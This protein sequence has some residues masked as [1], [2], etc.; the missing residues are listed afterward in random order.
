M[1]Q[2]DEKTWEERY[3]NYAGSIMSVGPSTVLRK[4]I[5]QAL[6]DLGLPKDTKVLLPGCGQNQHVPNS[7]MSVKNIA[8]VT[9]V[10]FPPVIA[11]IGPEERDQFKDGISLVPGDMLEVAENPEFKEA[12]KV[13]VAVNFPVAETPEKNTALLKAC[14]DCL[15]PG[16]YLIIM[17]PDIAFSQSLVDFKAT[18]PKSPKN[19]IGMKIAQKLGIFNVDND[20]ETVSLKRKIQVPDSD[21]KETRTLTQNFSSEYSIQK[22][23]VDA[24]F[25][26]ELIEQIVLDDPAAEFAKERA[27]APLVP[28]KPVHEH[29]V[30]ARKPQ[31]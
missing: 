12:F 19:A 10:D 7:I 16:G 21:K 20:K 3:E 2:Q 5:K 30:I 15:E 11:K 9:G 28:H 1:S 27:Y 29:F 4:R 18:F 22:K 24:G 17:A 8:S 6:T 14:Y 25:K 31:I 13:A 26:I 23:L